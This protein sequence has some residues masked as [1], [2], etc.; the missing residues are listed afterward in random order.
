MTQTNTLDR[1]SNAYAGS[2][3]DC[4]AWV[5]ANEGRLYRYSG[6]NMTGKLARRRRPRN[7]FVYVVRCEECYRKRGE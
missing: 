2:C 7:K 1:Q 4:N 5:N 3:I 6:A